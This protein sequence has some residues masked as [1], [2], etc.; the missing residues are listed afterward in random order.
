MNRW[1]MTGIQTMTTTKE[2]F[3]RTN[4]SDAELAKMVNDGWTIHF[5]Q[6]MPD[7][8]LNVVFV[9]DAKP[10]PAA[11][12]VVVVPVEQPRSVALSFN[13]L[14]PGDTRPVA[15]PTRA[16]V[17]QQRERDKAEVYDILERYAQRRDDIDR[18]FKPF[19]LGVQP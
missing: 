7:D 16:H 2:F 19:Q 13:R 4:C 10:A 1:M 18:T 8:K 17:R 3:I 5:M 12:P 9:R 6:F 11:Q 14:K 15:A